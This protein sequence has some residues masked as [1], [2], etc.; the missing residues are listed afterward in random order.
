MDWFFLTGMFLLFLFGILSIF[1]PSLVWK[2]LYSHTNREKSNIQNQ[3]FL[4]GIILTIFSIIIL[5]INLQ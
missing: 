2:L 5:L 1:R 3:I 4:F